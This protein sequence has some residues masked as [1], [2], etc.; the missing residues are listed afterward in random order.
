MDN[1]NPLE[2]GNP[3]NYVA[4]KS[5]DTAPLDKVYLPVRP[6]HDYQPYEP[7]RA[8]NPDVLAPVTVVRAERPKP[9]AWATAMLYLLEALR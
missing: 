9:T 4:R 5:L 8:S 2:S 7:I 6:V 3:S 1:F